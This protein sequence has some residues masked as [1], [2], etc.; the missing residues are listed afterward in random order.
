MT[1][2][3]KKRY[4]IKLETENLRPSLTHFLAFYY[5][6]TYHQWMTLQCSLAKMIYINALE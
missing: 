4:K 1:S 5:A 3:T 6:L 2:L